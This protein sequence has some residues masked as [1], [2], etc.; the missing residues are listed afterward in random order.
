MSD[1]VTEAVG[2]GSLNI[3]SITYRESFDEPSTSAPVCG[4]SSDN[5]KLKA[6]RLTE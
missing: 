1:K 5:L 2:S 3:S 6:N 4:T